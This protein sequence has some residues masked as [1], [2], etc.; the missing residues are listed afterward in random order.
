MFRYRSIAVIMST[1]FV[2]GCANYAAYPPLEGTSPVAEAIE[3]PVPEVI[4][5]AIEWCV[6]REDFRTQEKPIMFSL[7][8]SMG[9]GAHAAVAEQLQKDGHAS[10]PMNTDGIAIRS[11]RLFGL[12]AMVDLSVPRGTAPN[13][14]VTLEL[15]SYPFQP[16]HVVG[17][18]RWRFNEQQ[19]QQSTAEQQQV[20]AETG[21]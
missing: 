12:K 21:S 19:L 9:N 3:A 20:S 6:A 18:N 16:W 17:S 4:A 5:T 14:L 15:R 11:V 7:P 1:A 13:Q 10:M 8:P 2:A